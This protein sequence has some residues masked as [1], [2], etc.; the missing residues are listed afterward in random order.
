M[1]TTVSHYIDV[2][3]GERISRERFKEEYSVIHHYN[4]VLIK[5]NGDRVKTIFYECKR[6]SKQLKFEFS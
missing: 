3:T 5:K 4:E 2:E 6:R 1:W